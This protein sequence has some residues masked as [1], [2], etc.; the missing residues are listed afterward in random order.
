MFYQFEGLVVGQEFNYTH[1]NGTL[2]YFFSKKYFGPER[3]ARYDLHF[4]VY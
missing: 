1:L 2:D 4:Q 3:E